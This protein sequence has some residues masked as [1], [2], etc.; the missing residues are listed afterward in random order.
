MQLIKFN[1]GPRA[2]DSALH[3]KDWVLRFESDGSLCLTIR[4]YRDPS[5]S[6]MMRRARAILKSALLDQSYKLEA[7]VSVSSELFLEGGIQPA[8]SLIVRPK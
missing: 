4:A 3:G 8:R 7:E 1:N 5:D 6:Y 2:I